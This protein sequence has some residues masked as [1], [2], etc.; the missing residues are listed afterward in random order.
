WRWNAG[1]SVQQALSQS[2][3]S[4]FRRR[5]PIR[6]PP[7][8]SSGRSTSPSATAPADQRTGVYDYHIE[9]LAVYVTC[10]PLLVQLF[11]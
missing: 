2:G 8:P 5:V 3:A 6:H 11:S 9:L 10:S 7:H 4:I 1:R